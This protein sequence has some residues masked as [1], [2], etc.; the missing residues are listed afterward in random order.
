M[1][2]AIGEVY[3]RNKMLERPFI[4]TRIDN[5][6]QLVSESRKETAVMNAI[7]ENKPEEIASFF[8]FMNSMFQQFKLIAKLNQADAG[9]FPNLHLLIYDFPEKY[10][11][12]LERAIFPPWYSASFLSD[13]SNS[14][15]WGHY[16]E[17][18]RGVCLKFKTYED[19]GSQGLKLGTEYQYG[20]STAIRDLRT[21]PLKKINYHNQHPEIDFFRSIGRMTISELKTFWYSDGDNSLSECA[22]HLDNEHDWREKYWG[23]FYES[24]T[25]KLNEWKFE[26]EYRLIIHGD[27]MDY[28]DKATRKLKY[29]FNDLESIIF[30][31]KTTMADKIEIIKIVEGK[32]KASNRK[33]FDF[34]QAYYSKKT[35][36][37]KTLKL[38]LVKFS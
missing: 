11:S 37:I 33:S 36:N 10:L 23:N 32:C 24:L 9:Q 1:P 16:G 3:R 13:Y 6:S 30:G 8:L 5:L 14:S 2:G 15:L 28:T 26:Q 25:V 21:R 20:S 27:L 34:Q 12:K 17:N 7:G 35:G 4:S 31:I 38:D 29:D 18:H 22:A 19:T